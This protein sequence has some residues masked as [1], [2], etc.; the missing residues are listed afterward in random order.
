MKTIKIHNIWKSVLMSLWLIVLSVSTIP[1]FSVA[2]E[3]NCNR[4]WW[5]CHV[6]DI[7]TIHTQDED[8]NAWLLDTIKNAINWILW[9]LATVALV[10]CLYGWFMML[11][12]GSDTKW[13]DNWVKVL[14]NAAI[15]LAI[16]LLA[17]MIVSVIFRFVWTLSWWNQ[18]RWNGTT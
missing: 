7:H 12:S 3:E 6:W 1:W 2:Q 17:W 15:W 11:T 16:I 10:I 18:T 8:V 4:Y 13:Y 14:K 5:K 9:I